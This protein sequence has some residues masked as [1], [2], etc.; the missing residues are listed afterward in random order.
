MISSLIYTVEYMT[1]NKSLKL[2]ADEEVRMTMYILQDHEDDA[3][4]VED[5]SE[6]LLEETDAGR[7]QEMVQISMHHSYLPRME[8]AGVIEYDESA[9]MVIYDPDQDFED[10]LDYV[11]ERDFLVQ[12]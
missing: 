3:V 9:E 10:L 11:K 4:L 2:L 7:D 1:L 8:Q 6:E 12:S 5:L